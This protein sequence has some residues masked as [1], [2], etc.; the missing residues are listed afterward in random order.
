MDRAYAPSTAA[1][2]RTRARRK[3]HTSFQLLFA[4]SVLSALV[5][6]VFQAAGFCYALFALP[7]FSLT[8]PSCTASATGVFFAVLLCGYH[9]S[10]IMPDAV[11]LW[12]R[13][14]FAHAWVL[15]LAPL[16]WFLLSLAAWRALLQL[17][18][19]TPQRWEKTEH[20]LARTSRLVRR[21]SSV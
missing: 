16:Y 8:A 3:D 20:G 9:A 17:L 5:H 21:G 2:A 11:G 6:P 13:G 4:G 10:T 7:A 19:C 18:Y 12:R 14:L 15:L 1:V